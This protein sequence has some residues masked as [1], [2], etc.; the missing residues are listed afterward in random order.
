MLQIAELV[1]QQTGAVTLAIGDGANDVAMIQ[2]A[3]VGVGVAGLEGLQAAHSSDYAIG[4]FRFLARLLFV[5]GAWN[6]GRLT[7]VVLYS[8][9]KNICLYVMELWYAIY[10]GWS[11]QVVF[12]RW[13]I[14]AYNLVSL[15]RCSGGGG[16]IGC[17]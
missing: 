6:Y 16:G 7:Q 15:C 13:T 1:T 4:Q 14:A 3:Q 10:S 11:G 17:A 12:E 8:F 2:A 9:Y 5:H